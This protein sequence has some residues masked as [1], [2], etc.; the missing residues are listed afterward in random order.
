[1]VRKKK[2]LLP[3]QHL[4]RLLHPLRLLPLHLKQLP[5]VQRLRL[6]LL[7]QPH[8]L[9]KRLPLLLVPALLRRSNNS[10][11]STW[12]KKSHLRVAFLF[13]ARHGRIYRCKSHRKLITTNEEKRRGA[14]NNDYTLSRCRGFI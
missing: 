6:Q 3:L 13:C 12:L 5:Q 1:V 14:V 11:F 9:R 4:L 7:P 8:P 10:A 2:H